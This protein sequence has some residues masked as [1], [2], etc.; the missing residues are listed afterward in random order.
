VNTLIALPV[1]DKEQMEK[2]SD[3]AE[4]KQLIGN[5]IYGAVQ[6]IVGDHA[7]KITGMLLDEKVV[8]LDK[9]IVDQKYF[10]DLVGEAMRLL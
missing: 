5:A 7:G 2:A 3:I 10:S 8:D 1:V 6:P 9:L 4:K